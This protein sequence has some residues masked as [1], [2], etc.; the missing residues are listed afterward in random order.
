M[1]CISVDFKGKKKNSLGYGVSKDA[2]RILY[3][4]VEKQTDFIDLTLFD[5]V[6]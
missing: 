6:L 3:N 5:V 1:K 2:A 4:F